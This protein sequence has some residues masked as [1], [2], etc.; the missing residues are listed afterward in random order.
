MPTSFPTIENHLREKSSAFSVNFFID[1]LKADFQLQKYENL[2]LQGRT[3][4]DNIYDAARKEQLIN[5]FSLRTNAFNH[6]LR[7]LAQDPSTAP[8]V[9]QFKNLTHFERVQQFST[10]KA[11]QDANHLNIKHLEELYTESL[12]VYLNIDFV[13]EYYVLSAMPLTMT[14]E[15]QSQFLSNVKDTIQTSLNQANYLIFKENSKVDKE[16]MIQFAS[17]LNELGWTKYS[18]V[19]KQFIL[20]ILN[21]EIVCSSFRNKY[22]YLLALKDQVENNKWDHLKNFYGGNKDTPSEISNLRNKLKSLEAAYK[23]ATTGNQGSLNQMF[24][25]V[26]TIINEER[27]FMRHDG[28]TADLYIEYKEKYNQMNG[29]SSVQSNNT[30]PFSQLRKQ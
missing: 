25:E 11:R 7:S 28:D 23:Q 29:G 2:L 27:G 14:A 24:T 3:T 22:L 1:V 8:I 13:F 12:G 18:N 17:V 4:L 21:A 16:K 30:S 10:F 6:F 9:N 26:G 19:A 20:P 5:D 15:E